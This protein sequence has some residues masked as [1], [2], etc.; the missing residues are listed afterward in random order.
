M[1]RE[2]A[3]GHLSLAPQAMNRPTGGQ[4]LLRFLFP[5][6]TSCALAC[7]TALFVDPSPASA[8]IVGESSLLQSRLIGPSFADQELLDEAWRRGDFD[9]SQG[10]LLPS[11]RAEALRFLSYSPLASAVFASRSLN[12]GNTVPPASATA[13]ARGATNAPSD[14]RVQTPYDTS[15]PL[16][17]SASTDVKILGFAA[18]PQRQLLP[19]YQDV[20]EGELVD[21]AWRARVGFWLDSG[22]LENLSAHLRFV[23]DSEGKNDTHNRTRDF[24]QLGASNNLDEAYLRYHRPASRWSVTLGRRFLDWGPGRLGSL[25]LSTTAPAPDLIQGEIRLGKHRLQAFAGQISSETLFV[26][27][28]LGDSL[29]DGRTQFQEQASIQRTFYG[30]RIDFSLWS[31]G[32]LAL[33]ETAIVAS[34]GGGFDLKYANPVSIYVATQV[35]SGSGDQ[36]EVNIFHQLDGEAWWKGWHL[37]GAFVVDDLQVDSAGRKKWPDQLAGSA[38]LDRN[39]GRRAMVSYEYR[40]L[41][42]W[43]YL[44]RGSGTDAQHFE[45]PLGAP[46]GPDMERHSLLLSWRPNDATRLWV[47]GE[48]RRR[49]INRLWTAENR[50][51]HVGEPFPR[52]PVEKRWIA[53]AGAQWQ[54]SPW[55]KAELQLG[56]QSIEHVDNTD[57]DEDIFE[58]RGFIHL[59]SPSFGW[60]MGT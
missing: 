45:R 30:H 52:P 32:R 5:A 21:P 38:G 50:E 54:L 15:F 58:V 9:R 36:K 40:R 23:F 22:L 55:M 33:S 2:S 35:E 25:I 6:L 60:L 31:W 42:S 20:R 37:Y 18:N 59:F 47:S 7:A 1:P 41:G 13:A 28:T 49:G 53:Q 24:S 43:T 39:L 4:P 51:G 10:M 17:F 8:I 19:I 26:T 11:D 57:R 3:T 34:E 56:W 12:S 46:E 48:R 44:H 27:R 29:S 16:G 14:T